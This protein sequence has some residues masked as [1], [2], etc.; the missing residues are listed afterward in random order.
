MRIQQ[1][2]EHLAFGPEH[3]LLELFRHL[4][5]VLAHLLN[6]GWCLYF[7]LFLHLELLFLGT[8]HHSNVSSDFKCLLFV[9]FLLSFRISSIGCLLLLSHP[10][11]VIFLADLV[12]NLLLF[13]KECCIVEE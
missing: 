11:F 5:K 6:L 13:F 12:L 9:D 4:T 3:L 7:F 2:S 8:S 10:L 1:L